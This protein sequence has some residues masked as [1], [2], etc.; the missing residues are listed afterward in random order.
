MAFQTV[1]EILVQPQSI[2]EVF[3]ACR[4]IPGPLSYLGG[5]GNGQ[6][7]SAQAFAL[8]TVR[9][10]T[11]EDMDQTETYYV[12][13]IQTGTGATKTFRVRWYVLATNAEVANGTDLH[14]SSIRYLVIGN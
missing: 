13:V 4:P 14:L 8:L 1:Q 6:T 11:Q 7:I 5:A 2:G 9:Y 3:V 10:A 12:R